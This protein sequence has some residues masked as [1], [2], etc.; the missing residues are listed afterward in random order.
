M[1]TFSFGTKLPADIYEQPLYKGCS[2]T[3]IQA[4]IVVASFAAYCHLTHEG[5]QQLL[6]VLAILLPSDSR[7]PETVYLIKKL[8]PEGEVKY[9]FYCPKCNGTMMEASVPNHMKC[10]S[11]PNVAVI[12]S[13]LIKS[14]KYYLALNIEDQLRGLLEDQE[15]GHHL[16]YRF[17]R[18]RKPGHLCDLY[19]GRLYRE[20]KG[21]KLL[22]EKF[23]LSFTMNTDGVPAFK[24][25]NTSIWPIL[26][27]VNE[28]P[29]SLRKKHMI[30][31][32]LWY[33]SGKPNAN[34]FLRDF[35]S[36]LEKLSTTGFKWTFK[37]EL[38]TSTVD[39]L[40]VSLIKNCII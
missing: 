38:V 13:A 14:G 32:G 11:C 19:D 9:I 4:I 30:L 28:F 34:A 35:V 12:K 1:D 5:L 7:L 39:L 10:P 2:A 27:F 3:L 21:G 18:P 25:S 22:N 23:S 8:F 20:F 31:C 17:N 6:D 36:Q 33:G 24:S 37:N 16:Q 26:C 29:P 40:A 15:L